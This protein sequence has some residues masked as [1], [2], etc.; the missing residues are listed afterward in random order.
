[1]LP[2]KI[3]FASCALAVA[4]AGAYACHHDPAPVKPEPGETTPLPPSSGTPIGYIVDAAGDLK[5][6]DDQVTR[7]KAIDDAL[8]A[9]LETIESQLRTANRPADSGSS[10]PPQGGGGRHGGRGMRGGGMGGGGSRPH[11]NRGQ[12]SASGSGAGGASVARLTDERAAEVKD[13]L[14]RAFALLDAGQQDA[15]K[16]LLAAHDVDVETGS[17]APPAAGAEHAEP[18]EGEP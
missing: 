6:T 5:L 9:R 1:V 4:L 10:A 8:A 18:R 7:L 17:T 14:A 12:G 11:R 13:A 16:K 3:R 15:A 2:A